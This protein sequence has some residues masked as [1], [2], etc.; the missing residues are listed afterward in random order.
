MYARYIPPLRTSKSGGAALHH[1]LPQ[2]LDARAPTSPSSNGQPSV[3]K[4]IIFDADKWETSPIQSSKKRKLKDIDNGPI[5]QK[6]TRE[7]NHETENG[8]VYGKNLKAEENKE[9]TKEILAEVATDKF[10][11]DTTSIRR[12]RK[13]LRSCK[14][15]AQ[16]RD[17][18]R[19]LHAAPPELNSGMAVGSDMRQDH[20][21]EGRKER[22]ERKQKGA[23]EQATP[24]ATDLDT[25][26]KRHRTILMKK[27]KSMR[28]SVNKALVSEMQDGPSEAGFGSQDV[29]LELEEL[30]GLQPLPQPEAVPTDTSRPIYETLPQWLAAPTR[31]PPDKTAS[32]IGL[33]VSSEAAKVLEG[34]GYK[35]AFAVQT[36]AIP[37]LMPSAD[38]Q[39]DLVISAAT[40]SGKTLAYVLPM[41]RDIS[42]GVATRLRGVIVVPTRELVRQA[43]DACE[44]CAQA[45]SA[46][47]RKRVKIGISMGSQAFKHEQ[48]ALMEEE[49]RYDPAVH[50]YILHER[51]K[52]RD[53]DDLEPD[54]NINTSTTALPDHVIG[55][56][57]KV[58]ILICTPGRL[59]DHINLTPGFTLDYVRWLVVDEADK[60]LAQSFQKWLE[61]VTDRLKVDVPDTPV[62][63]ASNKTGV[64]KVVLSAT[65][66]RDLSL[67]S[68]LKLR[69]PKLI[70][71]E[72]AKTDENGAGSSSEHVLP[73]L[74]KESAIK[75]RDTSL[76]PLYLVDLL[77]SVH[78]ATEIPN[79]EVNA[80]PKTAIAAADSHSSFSSDTDSDSSSAADD[81][82]ATFPVASHKSHRRSFQTTALIFTK[83]NE[84]ALRLSRLVSLLAPHLGDLVGTLTSTTRTS[85]RRRTLRAF[86]SRKIRILVASDLVAR[87]VDLPNLD[88][89][90]NYDMPTSVASYVH[91][92]GRTARAG[93]T[94][95][96]WTLFT[97]TEA[98][99]FWPAIAGQVKGGDGSVTIERASK[100]NLVRLKDENGGMFDQQR[101]AEYEAALEKLGQ[102]A[103]EMR[104]RK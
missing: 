54:A 80:V 86:A 103:G 32:F 48:Y 30:H 33:G 64:Q 96:A 76:K 52:S 16:G 10:D 34:K 9:K 20:A 26:S 39:G 90:I 66:T 57:P 25:I 3:S 19:Q 41:V 47:G 78:M 27:E 37:F 24:Q 29:I 71:L 13:S 28:S 69:R 87:G 55:H 12:S 53:L 11:A 59:V 65:M 81:D 100:V 22:M 5:G 95:H 79:P 40:G 68:S 36:A 49:Q 72:G 74:L 84:T 18:G 4:K 1:H 62:A 31:V 99:W 97:K 94:G 83:S 101:V 17:T 77:S 56:I 35:E 102:E 42:E 38:K 45:F 15:A 88:H 14:A 70:V 85:Q 82:E 58:D 46:S 60:L 98:G 8:G 67:L 7:P 63:P 89:V 73:A 6:Q 61:I 104:Q 43:Q 50:R 75:V 91:R 21:E 2:R 23:M 92:V 44:A 93:G 51:F